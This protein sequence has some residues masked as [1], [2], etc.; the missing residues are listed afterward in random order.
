[1]NLKINNQDVKLVIVFYEEHSKLFTITS[2]HQDLL[3]NILNI[4]LCNLQLVF[5]NKYTYISVI[6][7]KLHTCQYSGLHTLNNLN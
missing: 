3:I 2:D 6:Q 7:N 5:H 4:R 1:M